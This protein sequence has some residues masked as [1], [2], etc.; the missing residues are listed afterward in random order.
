MP[1]IKHKVKKSKHTTLAYKAKTNNETVAVAEVL[2]RI[3]NKI[4]NSK[5]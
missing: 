5:R 3:T 2:A 1:A 4:C